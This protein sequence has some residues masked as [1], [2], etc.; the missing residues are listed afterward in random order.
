[1]RSVVA[2]VLA[3]LIVSIAPSA[4]NAG[5]PA[6]D[7][8]MPDRLGQD[9]NGDGMVDYPDASEEVSAGPFTVDL[10]TRPDLCHEQSTYSWSVEGAAVGSSRGGCSIQHRFAKEGTYEVE[11]A[12]EDASGRHASYERP[13]IVQ[14]WLVV[15]I[16]DS[17]ASGEGNPD[18]R[19]FV[20]RALWESPRCH[21]STL[22]SPVRAALALETSDRHTSTTFVHLACSGAAVEKGLL[23]G[24]DGIEVPD[25]PVPAVL[26]P[27]LTELEEIASQRKVDAVIVNAGAND[28]HFGDVVKFCLLVKHCTE[29][30][31]DPARADNGRLRR[32]EAEGLP[33]V[34]D[35]SLGKL[36]DS[37][38]TLRARL[39]QIEGLDP[40]HVLIVDYFDPTRDKDGETCAKIGIPW[41]PHFYIDRTEAAWAYSNL[42]APL[43]RLIGAAADR[44]GWTEVTGVA[45]AFRTHGYCAGR[46]AWIRTLG[47][48][49]LIQRGERIPSRFKGALH[50][51]E[52]GHAETAVLVSGAL[53]RT[54][55]SSGDPAPPEPTH[56]E[57]EEEEE[58]EPTGGGSEEAGAEHA[59][60]I[61]LITVFGFLVLMAVAAAVRRRRGSRTGGE[62]TDPDA[63]VVPAPPG[64]DEWPSLQ[65][66]HVFR[67]LLETFDKWVHRRV[68]SIEFID[69]RTIRRRVSV[70]F[71]PPGYVGNAPG[72]HAPIALLQK[73]VLTRFDLRD[74]AGDSLSLLTSGQNAAFATRYMLEVA[75]RASE[76]PPPQSLRDL[77]WRIARGEAPEAQRAIE[78]IANHLEPLKLR[79]DLRDS[80]L[81]RSVTATFAKS[82]PVVVRLDDKP[83]RRRVI[84][85][86]YNEVVGGGPKPWAQLG[87]EPATLQ[88]SLPELGDA[89]SRHIEFLRADGL[90]AFDAR[91]FART[92]DK[93]PLF[94]LVRTRGGR[95]AHVFLTGAPRGTHGVAGVRLRAR[96]QGILL[97]GPLFAT[98]AAIAL[99]AAWFALPGI[100]E[101]SSGVASVLLAVPA[102]L[103]AYLGARDPHPLVGAMLRGA[104]GLL[105]FSG[106]LSFAAAGALALDCSADTLRF[107]L[108]ISALLSWLAV[109]GLAGTYLL[110]RTPDSANRPKGH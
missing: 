17:V 31:F 18:A 71:T 103:G 107:V 98:L 35:A 39:E 42:L 19:G 82:F 56:E 12:V 50:P 33:A 90:E 69:E 76:I 68:E 62:P 83:N 105:F 96:R 72:L 80:Q 1:M 58:A 24:Y 74:E 99:T 47:K 32:T 4:A 40:G 22:A 61:G 59:A 81:F 34:I 89:A 93:K 85:F 106:V 14:D 53:Q 2:Q 101:D 78:K 63:A 11:L 87:L 84:K 44:A 13:V 37:Y 65:D 10:E 8:T 95:E 49:L 92:P 73:G 70:D 7:W 38:A 36:K 109:A 55:Y 43:N 46:R 86:A 97:G 5:A 75:E 51:D 102:A 41:L 66:T 9:S 21:R 25:D 108:G 28:L 29:K 88:I 57:E 104:R 94:R 52:N 26:R 67:D 27:Q 20:K 60:E 6:F 48:S 110:P 100:A 30:N 23:E 64:E 77:C 91:L 79:N 3:V 45:E 15:S 16:G 54:L